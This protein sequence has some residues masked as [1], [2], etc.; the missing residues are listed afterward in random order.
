MAKKKKVPVFWI[1]F[2]IFAAV[3]V[4]FWVFVISY[5]RKSLVIYENSQPEYTVESF[6]KGFDD[7][8]VFDVMD[9][10]QSGNR[11]E[12][13]DIYKSRYEEDIEG[14]T[15]TFEKAQASY[16]AKRPV[17]NI[18]ADDTLVAKLTLNEASNR[19]LMFILSE[20]KWEVEKLEAVYKTGSKEITITAPDTYSVFINN[21]KLDSRELT[22][23][24]IQ[25]DSLKYAAD[26]VAVPQLVKYHVEGLFDEPSVVIYN[27]Q[28]EQIMYSAD[29]NGDITIDT[30][31]TSAIESELSSMVLTN[32]KNYSNFF[33]RD[34]EGCRE[35]VA[36]I[37]YMFPDNS[38]Y[39]ELA[40][41]YRLNDMWMYSAHE[42]PVFT[43]EAVSNY[44]VYTPE[45]F[46]VEVY[47]VKN[48]TLTLNG[49]SRQDINNTRYYYAEINGE[50]LI[51]DMQSVTE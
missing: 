33:S 37:A 28:G 30:F 48:M 3:M 51:V 49:Q 18:Y 40:E 16:D 44:I 17:Y 6:L 38:Y 42:T 26:Y 22:G 23:E 15:I 25:I 21:V 47:F 32:A 35:S 36:P 39:L 8:S 34:I 19:Q 11:F 1:G 27:N 10:E 46:S 13:A 50:W 7:G 5:V 2:A 14:K 9:F 4:L 29:E 31:T 41:N 20:Q 45:L 24:T 12:N 43:D